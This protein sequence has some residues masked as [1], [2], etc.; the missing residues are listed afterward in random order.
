MIKSPDNSFNQYAQLV[1]RSVDEIEEEEVRTKAVRVIPPSDPHV[2]EMRG[3]SSKEDLR[4]MRRHSLTRADF[5]NL[6][7]ALSQMEQQGLL[8]EVEIEKL[9]LRWALRADVR[10]DGLTG[11]EQHREEGL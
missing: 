11:A 7:F 3:D 1:Y 4:N 6:F 5:C 10:A 2:T 8:T 9:H